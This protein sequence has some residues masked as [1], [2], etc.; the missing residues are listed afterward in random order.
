MIAAINR[1]AEATRTLIDSSHQF[2]A[3]VIWYAQTITTL[4]VARRGQIGPEDI[5]PLHQAL[6]AL[7]T[8]WLT[9][10]ESLGARE[11]RYDAHVD[12]L[13]AAHRE[14]VRAVER[15]GAGPAK[16]QP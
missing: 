9:R 15:L 4:A 5:E 1:N 6:N 12:A 16:P 10:W 2:Q 8:D 13:M 11:Q 14:L 7:G 3:H